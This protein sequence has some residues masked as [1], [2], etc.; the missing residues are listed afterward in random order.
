M[1][2][3]R[4][5]LL[6]QYMRSR[7]PSA[8]R[9][10]GRSRAYATISPRQSRRQRTGATVGLAIVGVFIGAL[11]GLVYFDQHD[12]EALVP[13]QGFRPC[14]EAKA[15]GVGQMWSWHKG[16]RPALDADHDG[17]ACEWN[18]GLFN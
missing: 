5:D 10:R 6:G 15:A 13:P 7:R 2:F 11:A 16:Y 4:E 1:W 12:S 14:A 8:A 17:R 18:A 9:F 3:L